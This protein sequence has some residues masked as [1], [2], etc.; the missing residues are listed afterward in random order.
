MGLGCRKRVRDDWDDERGEYDDGM[1]EVAEHERYVKRRP[2]DSS[3]L[4]PGM[5][6]RLQSLVVASPA[7]SVPGSPVPGLDLVAEKKD[8]VPGSEENGGKQ[9]GRGDDGDDDEGGDED[10]GRGGSRT[11]GNDEYLSIN[12]L[13]HSLA[14]ER[15]NRTT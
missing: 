9:G 14:L 5:T 11:V 3:E 15:A 8:G 12:A 10:G 4:T 6:Q 13:L 1:E 2:Y 7:T